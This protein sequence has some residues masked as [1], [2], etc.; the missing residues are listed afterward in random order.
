MKD[1]IIEQGILFPIEDGQTLN[2]RI[3]DGITEK[4]NKHRYQK[5]NNNNFDLFLDLPSTEKYGMPILTPYNGKTP[6]HLLP[7]NYAMTSKLHCYCIHFYI[8]DYQFERVWNNPELYCKILSRFQCVIGPDFSQY[9]NMSYPLRIYNCYRNRLI[10]SYL[11][12]NGVNLIPNVTWSLPDSY[13]YSFEGIPANSVI[14]INCTSIISCNLSKY[15]WY[16]GYNEAIRR[17]KPKLI[18]RYGTMMPGERE[19][20]SIYFD[21]ERL[22]MLRNGR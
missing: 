11:Q 18:I 13:D 5:M 12:K 19:D 9:R 16:K 8:D 1:K 6:T 20:I 3:D 21:N 4:K 15:L 22:K 10:S 17:L 14:A 7:F 2:N